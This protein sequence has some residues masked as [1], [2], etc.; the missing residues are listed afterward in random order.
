MRG[1]KYG[2]NS[3]KIFKDKANLLNYA[4]DRWTKRGP[5]PSNIAKSKTLISSKGV[6]ESIMSSIEQVVRIPPKNKVF[7]N[8]TIS[9]LAKYISDL[10]IDYIRQIKR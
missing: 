6:F 10:V 1:T 8:N 5:A 7:V 4:V 9:S 3:R 2:S